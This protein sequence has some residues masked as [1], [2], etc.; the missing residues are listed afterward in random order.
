MHTQF[1]LNNEVFT[2]Q[3]KLKTDQ[4]ALLPVDKDETNGKANLT[5]FGEKKQCIMYRQD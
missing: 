3:K 1:Y 4:C 2:C 5:T